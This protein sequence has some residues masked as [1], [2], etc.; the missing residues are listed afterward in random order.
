M[1]PFGERLRGWRQ[2]RGLSQLALAGLVGST[3]RHI[4]FLE[5]G[6]SRPSEQ[7]T[8][9]LAG[10]LDVG[11]RESNE[12][13]RAAGLGARYRESPLDSQH[14]LAYRQS[15][16]S[17]L[18]AHDPYPAMVLD[19]RFTVVLANRSALLL[20]GAG[21]VGANFVRDA[22]ANPAG[23]GHV[24]NWS[25]V[26]AGGLARLRQQANRDPFDEQLQTLVRQAESALA[27]LPLQDPLGDLVVCPTFVIDGT[28]VRTLSMVARFDPP[29]DVTV[30]ELRV[31]LMYPADAVAGQF[32]RE[33]FADQS[34][35]RVGIE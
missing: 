35:V 29:S 18:A 8:L 31:E 11:M 7:M 16:G 19:R 2:R 20:F 6:R 4:S 22:L 30:E 21:L 1:S 26:A 3:A 34:A 25:A 5:T 15:L 28:T 32:F 23:R 27:D 33:R 9:R 24:T 17:L 12:L 14:L 10:A 13:L